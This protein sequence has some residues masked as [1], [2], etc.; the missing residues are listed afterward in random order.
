MI[1]C[2]TIT[3]KKINNNKKKYTTPNLRHQLIMTQSVFR[4]LLMNTLAKYCCSFLSF[5]FFPSDLHFPYLLQPPQHTW[6][7]FK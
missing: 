1:Y 5:N 4:F 6:L 2:N 7:S 3:L